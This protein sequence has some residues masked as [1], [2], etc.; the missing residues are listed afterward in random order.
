MANREKKGGRGE[1][2]NT[3]IWISQEQ[4]ELFRWKKKKKFFPI[5]FKGLSFGVKIKIHKK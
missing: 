4:K 2:G 3:K 1:E 5:V